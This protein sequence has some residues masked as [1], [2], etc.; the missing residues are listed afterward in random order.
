MKLARA[1]GLKNIWVSNGFMSKES[2]EMVIPYLD[3]NNIDI[4]SF[5]DEFYQ[6]NCGARLAPDLRPTWHPQKK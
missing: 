4:K 2:A 1:S 5:S 6:K 3:A